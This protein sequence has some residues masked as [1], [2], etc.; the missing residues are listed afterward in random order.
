M[1][2][3][4]EADNVK[5]FL[6]NLAEKKVKYDVSLCIDVFEHVEDYI[7]FIRSLKSKASYHVFHI[8]LDISVLAVIKNGFGFAYES[9][10]HLHYFSADT[11]ITTLQEAGYEVVDSF[12]TK[13]YDK[14]AVPLTGFRKLI[15]SI[16]YKLSLKWC[17]RII[18]G[19]ELLVLAKAKQK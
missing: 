1:C 13:V 5:F 18:G 15:F 6:E 9:V 10:G 17:A 14:G 7:G 12:Y 4:K 16:G 8:P 19:C 11:A 3:A 2:K